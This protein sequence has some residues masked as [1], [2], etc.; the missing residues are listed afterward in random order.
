[1]DASTENNS[2]QT[3][4]DNILNTGLES[5]HSPNLANLTASQVVKDV[6]DIL[7]SNVSE[8]DPVVAIVMAACIPTVILLILFACAR[9]NKCKCCCFC[10]FGRRLVPNTDSKDDNDILGD[11]EH[12]PEAVYTDPKINTRKKHKTKQLA[13]SLDDPVPISPTTD[14]SELE[15]EEAEEGE[16]EEDTG[17][18]GQ[19]RDDDDM[20]MPPISSTSA[21]E[22]DSKACCGAVAA[23]L[24]K[25]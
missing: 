1:M 10:C 3:F 25:Q 5:L 6:I 13:S 9:F 16:E 2:F 22:K 19:I 21:Y 8:L 12:D 18:D 17:M 24:E 20:E 23:C 15:E 4:V 7:D 14:G 11:D